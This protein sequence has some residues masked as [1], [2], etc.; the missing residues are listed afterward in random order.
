ML[1]PQNVERVSLS[2]PSSNFS[3]VQ[4][5]Y[6]Q[7]EVCS[8]LDLEGQADEKFELAGL[9]TFCGHNTNDERPALTS[10]ARLDTN[11]QI[12]SNIHVTNK[13][14]LDDYLSTSIRLDVNS[15]A[16]PRVPSSYEPSAR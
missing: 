13:R 11:N 16:S 10:H 5:D 8:V 14:K 9:T 12:S 3:A 7:A 1:W 4:I 2:F 15:P 6:S